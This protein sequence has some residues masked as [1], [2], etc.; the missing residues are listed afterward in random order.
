MVARKHLSPMKKSSI[1]AKYMDLRPKDA[2]SNRFLQ[3]YNSK[4]NKCT[5]HV[6]SENIYAQIFKHKYKAEYFSTVT[7]CR[8]RQNQKY[9]ESN[10]YFSVTS[11]SSIIHWARFQKDFC[12]ISCR[13]RRRQCNASTCQK[14]EIYY[15]Y[16]CFWLR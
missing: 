5:N 8:K 7:G 2:I 3:H 9:T 6:S 4:D 13:Q 10:C 11:K 16:R 14:L 15:C 1:I 12:N